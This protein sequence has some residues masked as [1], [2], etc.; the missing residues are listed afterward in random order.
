MERLAARRGLAL[1]DMLHPGAARNRR[2][3]SA[4][5]LP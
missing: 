4:H 2:A 1:L 5:G 3:M